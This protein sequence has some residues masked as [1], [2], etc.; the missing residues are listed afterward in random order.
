MKYN[1]ENV[2]STL[3]A[4]DMKRMMQLDSFQNIKHYII[5]LYRKELNVL[6]IRELQ[7]INRETFSVAQNE[8]VRSGM[9]DENDNLVY[10]KRLLVWK[11]HF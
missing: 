1:L 9:F 7:K 3:L 8:N 11:I 5:K 10:G 6:L 4:K 2:P